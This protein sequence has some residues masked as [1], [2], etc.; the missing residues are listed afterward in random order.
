[1]S[2]P[3]LTESKDTFRLHVSTAS[4]RILVLW[5]AVSHALP[6][7]SD[8]L[9]SERQ[10]RQ[11]QDEPPDQDDAG[12]DEGQQVHGWEEVRVGLREEGE[13]PTEEQ[14]VHDGESQGGVTESGLHRDGRESQ[15][16]EK[17]T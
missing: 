16:R 6:A 14:S 17:K 13:V 2:R 5:T 1:M 11:S 3:T 10:A 7:P 4:R 15:A 8:L 9:Q 12:Q